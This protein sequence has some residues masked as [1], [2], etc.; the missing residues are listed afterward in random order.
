MTQKARVCWRKVGVLRIDGNRE[1]G[2]RRSGVVVRTDTNNSEK[3][4]VGKSGNDIMMIGTAHFSSTAGKEPLNF[5][6]LKI[7]LSATIT[8]KPIGQREGFSLVIGV[9]PSMSRSEAEH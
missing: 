5:Q 2:S 8:I 1:E 7:A 9:C 3:R 4:K 6:L